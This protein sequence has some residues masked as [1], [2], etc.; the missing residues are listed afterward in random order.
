MCAEGFTRAH[1]KNPDTL[2]SEAFDDC[3]ECDCN[4]HSLYPCDRDSGKWFIL[5]ENSRSL[6]F[7]FDFIFQ[8]I[9]RKV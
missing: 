9:L 7:I 6:T 3:V 4:Q 1:A 5:L 2:V 8:T